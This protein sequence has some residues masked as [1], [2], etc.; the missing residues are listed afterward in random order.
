MQVVAFGDGHLAN[1]QQALSLRQS[2]PWARPHWG[3]SAG[4]GLRPTLRHVI[5][6]VEEPQHVM[7]GRGQREQAGQGLIVQKEKV[8]PPARGRGRGETRLG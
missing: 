5:P 1:M 8:R 4:P 3:S 7:V 2:P 6:L